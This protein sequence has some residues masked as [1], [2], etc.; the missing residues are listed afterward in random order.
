MNSVTLR[1]NLG[2]FPYGIRTTQPPPPQREKERER[3]KTRLET[4]P[5]V[6]THVMLGG[7]GGHETLNPCHAR[8]GDCNWFRKSPMGPREPFWVAGMALAPVTNTSF[9]GAVVSVFSRVHTHTHT[10]S[11]KPMTQTSFGLEPKFAYTRGQNKR[12]IQPTKD[13]TA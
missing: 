10:L 1:N 6:E 11:S 2:Y 9:H 4:R 3:A 13:C 5:T 12:A 7:G 8:G